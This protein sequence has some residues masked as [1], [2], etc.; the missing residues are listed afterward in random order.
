MKNLIIALLL[1]PSRVQEG[2]LHAQ[3]KIIQEQKEGVTAGAD[4][5]YTV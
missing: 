1:P 3:A 2:D 5:D 4:Q